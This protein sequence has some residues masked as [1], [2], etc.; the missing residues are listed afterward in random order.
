MVTM[1]KVA[2]RHG[3]RLNTKKGKTECVITFA[4]KS[5]MEARRALDWQEE[6]AILRYGESGTLRL[7]DDCKHLGTLHDKHL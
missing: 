6:H 7:V 2:V 1:E 3:F 4:S 5:I